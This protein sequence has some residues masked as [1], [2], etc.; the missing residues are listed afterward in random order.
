MA[1]AR[2]WLTSVALMVT[3][4][5]WPTAVTSTRFRRTLRTLLQPKLP[6]GGLGKRSELHQLN[7]G[8][9][10]ALRLT[11]E[12]AERGAEDRG[13]GVLVGYEDLDLALIGRRLEKRH[14]D[15]G[16]GDDDD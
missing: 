10:A 14:H 6:H 5:V 12:F 13:A 4:F 2:S 1:A 11:G 8:L 16:E 9:K 7:L 3:T 15:G